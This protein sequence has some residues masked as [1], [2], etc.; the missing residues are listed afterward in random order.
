MG[1]LVDLSNVFHVIELLNEAAPHS[2]FG[3]IGLLRR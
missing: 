1:A 2:K 3:L